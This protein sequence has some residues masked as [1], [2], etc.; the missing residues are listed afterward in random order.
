MKRMWMWVFAF[1]SLASLNFACEDQ[2]SGP[3]GNIND[4]N[5]A[6]G[7]LKMSITDAPIDQASVKAVFVTISEIRVDGETFE[8]FQGP[9][10]IN[11]LDLQN[12]TSLD[13]GSQDVAVGSYSD[14]TLVLD[15]QTSTNGGASGCYIEME[16]GTTKDLELE[17][18]GTIELNLQSKD[19][20]IR[21]AENTELIFDFDL[22][23][24]IK[25]K[26]NGYAF[27]NKG[28]LQSAIRVEN[29]LAC[30]NISGK[31][32][33]MLNAGS[34]L[35]V[36]AYEKGEFDAATETNGNAEVMYKHA[37]TS[38]KVDANGNYTLAFL[39]EGEYEIVC[40]KPEQKEGTGAW[41]NTLLELESALDL[42]S[43]QV[44][45][46]ASVEVD[47]SVKLDGVLN[48]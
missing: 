37:V 20:E 44:D 47:F 11:V 3:D 8:G 10:T 15:S 6:K 19:F 42:N 2:A 28:D 33:N 9:Q 13:L 1:V 27:V 38:A 12:G 39:P 34:N 18:N 24:S 26:A 31:V 25:T 35:V 21:E 17:G 41:F 48:L 16:D 4:P 29:K 40:A 36:Y 30:G 23:K 43:V 45:A 46:G 7:S 22:R 14:I 32:D 5:A